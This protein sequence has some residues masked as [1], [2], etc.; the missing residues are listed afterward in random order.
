MHT[1]SQ[2]TVLARGGHFVGEQVFT[3]VYWDAKGC[4]LTEIDWWLRSRAG[5]WELKV[6]WKEL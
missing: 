3:D 4:G 5:R 6:K 1:S 2:E